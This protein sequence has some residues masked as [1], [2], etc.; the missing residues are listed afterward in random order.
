LKSILVVDDDS[1]TRN[2]L[3]ELFWAEGYEVTATSGGH[4]AIRKL[5][6][7]S[8]PHLLVLDVNM[9]EGNGYDVLTYLRA[10]TGLK[11]IP[12]ILL[13]ASSDCE[14][15]IARR[16]GCQ[17]YIRKPFDVALLTSTVSRL[18]KSR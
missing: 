6:A 7:G 1:F 16:L 15:A 18:I 17:A 5:A 14:V 8:V 9:P 4:S 3:T 11:D 2:V 10:H 13:T 12:V